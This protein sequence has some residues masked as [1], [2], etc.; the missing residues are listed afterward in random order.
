[1]ATA[2]LTKEERHSGGRTKVE[3]YGWNVKDRPGELQWIRKSLLNVD[4]EYQRAKVSQESVLS[5]ARNWSWVACGVLVV[6]RRN[7][8]TLWVVDGQTR[9]TAAD[10]RADVNELPCIVFESLELA[11]E[12]S[13]FI[14]VNTFRRPVPRV[15]KFRAQIV[16]QDQVAIAVQQ[17]IEEQ[18]YRVASGSGSFSVCCIGSIME[19]FKNNEEVARRVWQLCAQLHSGEPIVDIIWLGLCYLE[20]SLIARKDGESIFRPHNLETLTKSGAKR[21]H[22]EIRK[23]RNYFNKGGG[24]VYAEGILNLLNHRRTA[25]RIKTLFAEE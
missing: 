16:A 20:R 7:D 25:R 18:G 15:D 8:G 17:M 6:A 9:K 23:A 11:E 1:M 13:A 5:I 14:D 2:T 24:K 22:E 4:K 10:K 12:A 21:I 3:A 19:E